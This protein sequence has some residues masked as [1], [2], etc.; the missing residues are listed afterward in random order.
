MRQIHSVRVYDL[1]VP[2]GIMSNATCLT[3]LLGS[4]QA[5]TCINAMRLPELS[6]PSLMHGADGRF[7]M[8]NVKL[9]PTVVM[10][11]RRSPAQEDKIST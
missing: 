7:A 10:A 1:L 4:K 11:V 6:S 9:Y 8:Q 2:S 5:H 3:S